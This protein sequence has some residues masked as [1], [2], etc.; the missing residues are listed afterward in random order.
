MKSDG[1]ISLIA[2][3]GTLM[4]GVVIYDRSTDDITGLGDVKKIISFILIAA[5]LYVIYR[6]IKSDGK[7]D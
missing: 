6:A 4:G 5:G 1:I 3:I 2:G 7:N